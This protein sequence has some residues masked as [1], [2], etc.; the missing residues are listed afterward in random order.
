M[1]GLEE[2]HE[3]SQRGKK[4]SGDS[5]LVSLEHKPGA[6]TNTILTGSKY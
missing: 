2:N 1:K 5:N 4:Y 3:K 6:I